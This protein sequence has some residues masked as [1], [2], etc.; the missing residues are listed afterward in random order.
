MIA[1]RG[2]HAALPHTAIDP[3]VAASAAV[4]AL[5]PLVSRETAPTDSAV[6][7]VTRF[8]TGAALLP[9]EQLGRGASRW[10]QMPHAGAGRGS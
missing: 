8:N 4:L 9:S 6:I 10:L 7:S 2:G 3:V 5:Q 1:G